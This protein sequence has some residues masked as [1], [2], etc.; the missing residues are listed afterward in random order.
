MPE[1]VERSQL[2]PDAP[3]WDALVDGQRRPNPFFRS[4]WLD[5]AHAGRPVLALVRDGDRLLGG[6]ALESG[7]DGEALVP[8]GDDLCADHVDLLAAPG[9][10]AVVASLLGAWLR[11][12]GS[13]T[14]DLGLVD[15][16]GSRIRGVLPRPVVALATDVAPF[17]ELPGD[18]AEYLAGRGGRL[19]STIDRAGRRLAKQGITY[20]R[21]GADATDE[22]IEA[23]RRLHSER[24]GQESR[25]VQSFD[26]FARVARAGAAR[27]EVTF[28]RLTGDAGPIA[29]LVTFDVAGSSSYYQSGRLTDHEWRGS[30]T[31]LMGRVIEHL[32]SSGAAELDFLRGDEAYKDDW[33]TGR[34]PLVHLR[35]AHGTSARTRLM[36]VGAT[37]PARRIARRLRTAG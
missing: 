14:L 34:R 37:Q 36:L 9:E 6:L 15:A 1:I 27:G 30:G 7:G 2:G 20:D 10:E 13:R 23:L 4:W 21:A 17:A 11:R 12:P 8:L 25:F 35:A 26:R 28:H 3:A 24:W 19:R 18:P 29:L 31:V 22:A 33:A 5:H 32:C 16:E